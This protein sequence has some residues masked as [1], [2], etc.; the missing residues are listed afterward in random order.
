MVGRLRMEYAQSGK[1]Y[2]KADMLK[3]FVVTGV[4]EGP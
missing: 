2:F 1:T 4:F 3:R